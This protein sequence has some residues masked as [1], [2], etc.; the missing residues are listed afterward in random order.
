[1]FLKAR[2]NRWVMHL[3]QR[4]AERSCGLINAVNKLTVHTLAMG[5]LCQLHTEGSGW[6]NCPS[7][8]KLT[9]LQL[10]WGQFLKIHSGKV[11]SFIELHF[12]LIFQPAWRCQIFHHQRK[13]LLWFFIQASSDFFLSVQSI[14]RCLDGQVKLFTPQSNNLIH[15][16]TASETDACMG[17][18]R[19]QYC[20]LLV[21]AIT[22]IWKHL[23]N[24]YQQRMYSGM[25]VWPFAKCVML[26]GATDQELVA[27]W[28]KKN[29]AVFQS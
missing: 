3:T 11:V 7:L 4:A 13:I 9:C 21:L 28:K 22:A 27:S 2:V 10:T 29:I 25:H 24:K 20:L 15:F 17:V 18:A 1:M 19:T 12:I 14:C 26:L 16:G 5:Y 23:C 8:Y 6:E